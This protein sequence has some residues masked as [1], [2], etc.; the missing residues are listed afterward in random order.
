MTRPS[1]TIVDQREVS[2]DGNHL[3]FVTE[4]GTGKWLLS[5][6]CSGHLHVMPASEVKAIKYKLDDAHWC[7][8]C[9]QPLPAST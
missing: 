3:A 9:E 1:F 7:G 4:D 6:V 8:V 2:Y 5:F